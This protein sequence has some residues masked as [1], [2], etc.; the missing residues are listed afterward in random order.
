MNMEMCF[1]A[2]DRSLVVEV[3]CRRRMSVG[4]SVAR[5]QAGI[6]F[7]APMAGIGCDQCL[8]SSHVEMQR[9]EGRVRFP[10]DEP[11]YRE[12]NVVEERS[13]VT[14]DLCFV[15]NVLKWA[16]TQGT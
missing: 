12:R 4:Y 10:R 5:R 3:V 8:Q 1:N 6:R 7:F 2:L 9:V 14:C 13:R 11:V 16:R 15:G